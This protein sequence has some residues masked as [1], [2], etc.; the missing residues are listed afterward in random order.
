MLLAIDMKHLQRKQ[1][2]L[3]SNRLKREDIPTIFIARRHLTDHS[4]QISHVYPFPGLLSTVLP[5]SQQTRQPQGIGCDCSHISSVTQFFLV[6]CKTDS[7]PPHYLFRLPSLPHFS[8]SRPHTSLM[9]L[10]HT[11]LGQGTRSL[12]I[13]AWGMLS[14]GQMHQLIY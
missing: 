6:L 8:A 7:R 11:I 9:L 4:V 12:A 10:P 14:S 3:L 5:E 2:G 13:L 1:A